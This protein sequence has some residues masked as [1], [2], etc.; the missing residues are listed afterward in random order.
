MEGDIL[1]SVASWHK[2][3]PP[4]KNKKWLIKNPSG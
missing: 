2:F 1:K 3:R 4:T